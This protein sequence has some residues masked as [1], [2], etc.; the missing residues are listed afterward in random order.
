MA[1]PTFIQE[2][3]TE[4]NLTT[5]P[6][7][8]GNF[9]TQTGDVVVAIAALEDYNNTDYSLDQTGTNVTLAV[10]ETLSAVGYCALEISAG[11][12]ASGGT[13]SVSFARG[14]ATV[15]HGGN[16]LTFRGSDGVGASASTNTTGAPSLDITTTQANSALVVIVADWSVQDGSSRTWRTVNSITPTSGNGYELTYGVT[17]GYIVYACYYPDAGAIGTKTVG[18]S[19]PTGQTYTIAALEIKGTAG[20]SSNAPRAMYHLTQ[21]GIS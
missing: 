5:T 21:Q 15:R 7:G 11:V 1:A 3:E 17:T 2:A 16:A 18:L 4:W 13:T 20:G 6:K 14:I 8:S 19:A 12:V 10:E 9:T